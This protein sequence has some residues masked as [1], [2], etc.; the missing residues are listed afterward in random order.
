[1]CSSDL[2]GSLNQGIP[3]IGGG[4]IGES[5]DI[6]NDKMV[7]VSEKHY[8]SMNK[9]Q[10]Q[11]GDVLIVKDGATTGKVGFYKGE[12]LKAAINEHIFALRTKK[13][14]NNYFLYYLLQGSEFQ[15]KLKPF[16]QGI[17]GGINLKFSS[18]EIPN[19]SIETQNQIVEEL[20]GY[21]KII[22]GCRQVIE[23]YKPSI[24]IDPSWE[25]TELKDLSD[26]IISG[27][28][29]DSK[30]FT[31]KKGV[32][33]IK[34]TNVGINKF[35]EKSESFLPSNYL[36]KHNEFVINKGDIVVALTRTI[37][38]G[39]AKVSIVPDTFNKSLLNQRVAAI[40]INDIELKKYIYITL[41]SKIFYSY[42]ENKSSTLMQPNLSI[43]DLKKYPIYLPKKNKIKEIV[44]EFDSEMNAIDTN[45]KLLKNIQ[46]K[47]NNKINHILSK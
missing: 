9:G 36:E 4:Q 23:N 33:V 5:G 32:Q 2:G 15:K 10:L 27:Y 16:I 31:E 19:P 25:M 7:F 41:Q 11:K 30:D 40:R 39:G 47:I 34:I 42:V 8:N 37:I 24:D 28:S 26:K 38:S 21:Q 3:S 20:D 17:I 43:N 35:E 12:F 29:F 6:L 46:K 45:Y 44:E 18:I 13:N 22:D 1:V 14:Y